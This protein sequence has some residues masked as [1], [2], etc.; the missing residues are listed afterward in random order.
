MQIFKTFM[1]SDLSVFSI[2]F[3]GFMLYLEMPSSV[4][5]V[6]NSVSF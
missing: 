2:M 4:Y 5:M 3:L 1:L 6:K